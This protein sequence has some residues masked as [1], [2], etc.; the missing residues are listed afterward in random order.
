MINR[1][2]RRPKLSVAQAI[3]IRAYMQAHKWRGRTIAI[4]KKYGVSTATIRKSLRET[5][6]IALPPKKPCGKATEAFH[7]KGF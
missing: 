1:A 5:S 6:N 7:R 2:G 3:E 4:A